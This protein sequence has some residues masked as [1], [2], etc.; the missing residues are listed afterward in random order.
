MK[1]TLPVLAVACLVL[2]FSVP[3]GA[4]GGVLGTKVASSLGFRFEKPAEG[5]QVG[6]KASAMILNSSKLSRHGVTAKNNDPVVVTLTGKYTLTVLHVGTGK[7]V[8]FTFDKE[9]NVTPVR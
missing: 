6:Q 5:I 9:G 1:K 2:L 8:N 7:S 4:A 3:A